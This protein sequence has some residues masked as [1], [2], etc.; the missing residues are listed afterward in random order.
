MKKL[1][2]LCIPILLLGCNT[3]R[4]WNC[5]QTS[6]EI[7]QKQFRVGNFTDIHVLDR[8]QL[9]LKQGETTEVIVETG[10]NLM[11]EVKV[12]VEDNVLVINNANSCNLF[13]EYGITKAYVTAPDITVLR[14]G[15]GLQVE[16]VG[17]LR[18]N[19]LS[20]ISEDFEEEDAL[21][22]DGDFRLDLEVEALNIIANNLSNFYLSG[23]AQRGNFRVFSGD[24][25]IE[26]QNLA[27]QDLVVFH[28]GTNKMI[29]NPIM[30]LT[31]E[32]RG[33]GDVIAVN[34]PELVDVQEYYTGRLI[35]ED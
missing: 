14:N 21:Y 18:Y 31:G 10:E 17:T 35:F 8:V 1:F 16:S 5:T 11:I 12:Y 26:S 19:S 2:V 27:V 13:R 25:R 22:T 30:S 6:G 9:F 3:E 29:V 24:V 4:S 23:T 33:G 20:L 32:I 15:S 34:R 28:R 7:I